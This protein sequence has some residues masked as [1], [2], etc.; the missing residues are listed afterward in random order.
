M[1][2]GTP[3]GLLEP[4]FVHL[5]NDPSGMRCRSLPG[6]KERS[7]TAKCLDNDS[8]PRARQTAWIYLL[9]EQLIDSSE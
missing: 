8:G 4:T 5:I 1:T 2:G 9:A 3:T 7:S 6:E